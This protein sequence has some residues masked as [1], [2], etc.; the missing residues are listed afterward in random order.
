MRTCQECKQETDTK[1]E[2]EFYNKVVFINKPIP[3]ETLGL[4]CMSIALG[5]KNEIIYNE[6]VLVRLFIVNDHTGSTIFP[7]LDFKFMGTFYGV[8]TYYAE[9]KVKQCKTCKAHLQLDDKRNHCVKCV[10]KFNNKGE[11]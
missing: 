10:G 7:K 11:K 4:R 1:H 3:E 6:D 8:D 2:P 5:W 9:V